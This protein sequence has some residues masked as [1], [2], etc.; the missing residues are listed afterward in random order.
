[1]ARQCPESA[2]NQARTA[3][4][5]SAA[6]GLRSFIAAGLLESETLPVQP[7]FQGGERAW[8]DC[9]A[10]DGGA[11]AEARQE[12]A[13]L[14]DHRQ[15]PLGAIACLQGGAQLAQPV[16]QPELQAAPAGPEFAGEERCLV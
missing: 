4:R 7:L 16:G 9:H 3:A 10:V 2:S 1:M 14:R 15:V 5:S 6:T 12:G 11:E 8:S 13:A